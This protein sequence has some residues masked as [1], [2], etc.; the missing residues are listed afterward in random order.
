[1]PP[2]LM[3]VM[4]FVVGVIAA[5]AVTVRRYSPRH[6]LGEVSLRRCT[7]TYPA[8][9]GGAPPDTGVREPCRPSGRGP[10][11]AAAAVEPPDW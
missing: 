5:Q 9:W 3:L 11:D 8:D 7:T 10:L 4:G 1:M 6:V 2:W